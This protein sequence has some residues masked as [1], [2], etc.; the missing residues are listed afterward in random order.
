MPRVAAI[1]LVEDRTR[2]SRCDE[3]FL[4]VRRYTARNR[5]AD[6]SASRDYPIDV[7][8]RPTLDAVAVCLWAAGPAGPAVLLRRQLRPAA[9]FR[10]EQS[11]ALP[12]PPYLLFEEV[13]AGVLEPGEKGFEALQRRAAAEVA[14]EAGIDLA[15]GRFERLGGPFFMLPGTASEKIHLVHAEVPRDGRTGPWPAPEH[16]DG[17]P[18]EE[19]AELLWRPLGEALAACD[20]GEIEDAKT[21]LA[22]HRL[23]VLLGA[24]R[25]AGPAW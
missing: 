25:G 14:E 12:E 11:P 8:E 20:R 13:V 7:I 18:L 22:L 6:G 1:E 2:R 19:G 4:H 23:L 16:G 5:R 3:G 17:S 21:E 9:Y 10:R 15:P 24:R